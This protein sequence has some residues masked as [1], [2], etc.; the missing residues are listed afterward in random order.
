MSDT[1]SSSGDEGFADNDL[2]NP[3]IVTK[4]RMAG[5]FANYALQAVIAEARVGSRV[6]DLCKLGDAKIL[7][8]TEPVFNKPVVIKGEK[9][10]VEKGVAFPTSI[11]VN[12]VL[13]FFSPSES[14]DTVLQEGDVAKI[15]LAAHIDGYIGSVTHTIVIGAPATGRRADAILAAQ[16]ALEA[17]LR[18][19]RPGTKSEEFFKLA[20]KVGAAYGVTPVEG[21]KTHSFKRFV[22]EA[23]KEVPIKPK[24]DEK[25]DSFEVEE[26]DVFSVEM[27]FTTGEDGK[28][29]GKDGI[30]NVYRRAVDV[31][32][33]LKMKA[34]R[35]VFSEINTAS[36]V[37]AFN[38]RNLE[39]KLGAV[40]KLGLKEIN[41]HQL[42]HPYLV[43]VDKPG[44]FI[45]SFKATCLVLSSGVLR[46][47]GLPYQAVESEKKLE[48]ADV[49]KLLSTSLKKNKKKGKKK[50]GEKAE[51]GEG[52]E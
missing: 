31:T 46:L 41:E 7:E 29:S 25:L 43:L 33:M 14:D 3:D 11:S 36:P 40:S 4:Y 18:L 47:T 17:S 10:K 42:L 6:V 2:N 16:N 27:A 1:E 30:V 8:K 32:Y 38:L 50:A 23:S 15:E 34:S 37:F 28:C 24:V 5:E 52:D 35:Q 49:L 48:D 22:I 26:G 21:V 51:E 9:V 44:E 19:L 45:A 12:N 39:S 13:S 20:K